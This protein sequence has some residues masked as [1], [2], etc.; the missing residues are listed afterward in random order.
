MLNTRQKPARKNK[1]KGTQMTKEQFFYEIIKLRSKATELEP[2]S[3][4]SDERGRLYR[5][6]D[7]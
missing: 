6:K 3:H 5:D 4:S 1:M 2:Q 7:S